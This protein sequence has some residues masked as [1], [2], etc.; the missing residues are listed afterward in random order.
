MRKGVKG[1]AGLL[2]SSALVLGMVSG[3]GMN[4]YAADSDYG[5]PATGEGVKQTDHNEYMGYSIGVNQG[6]DIWGVEN[7]KSDGSF[8]K[9]MTTC[10]WRGYGVAVKVGDNDVKY[11]AN[12]SGPVFTIGKEYEVDGVRVSV[13]LDLSEEAVI[14]T[15]NV[16]NTTDKDLVVKVGS[17]GDTQIGGDDWCPIYFLGNAIVMEECQSGKVIRKYAMIS[18]NEDFDT[19]W[20]GHYQGGKANVFNNSEITEYKD[21]DIDCGL[22]FSWT[23]DVPAN[24]SVSTSTSPAAGELDLATITYDSNGGEGTM[25]SS[26]A[27]K[28]DGNKT[29]LTKNE[30][31]RE[32]YLF[33]GWSTSPDGEVEFEDNEEIIVPKENTTL[34]AVWERYRDHVITANDVEIKYGETGTIGAT[35]DGEGELTYKIVEGDDIIELDEKTGAIKAKKLGEAKVSVTAGANLFYLEASKDIKVTVK[36][37]EKKDLET[38]KD[39]EEAKK[40]EDEKKASETKPSNEWIDG[41]WY[42]ADGGMTYDGKGEWK[43]NSSGWWFEDSNGWYPNDQWQ[44]IDGKWYYFKADGYLDYSE[45]RDGFWLG[46]DGAWVEDYYGGTWKSDST[47]WWFEDASGWYPTSQWVWINGSCYYFGADGYMLTNQYVDGYWVG[48]DGA[49]Q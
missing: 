32:G 31:T 10:K 27:I 42:D 44:K 24:S 20:I 12:T 22:A 36:E 47:G 1:I 29:F 25:I 5:E 33:M 28:G 35:T 43:C 16:T 18:G 39:V 6:F 40:A 14:I 38:S 21:D 8:D 23:L 4:A 17:W 13:D 26:T 41:Q 30:F 49:S 7:L 11:L 48:A 15:Y 34:Y 37:A 19:K 45:Y 3:L 9:I 2:L 46:S